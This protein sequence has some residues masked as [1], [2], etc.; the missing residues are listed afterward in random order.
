MVF[1]KQNTKT[2]FNYKVEAHTARL[3]REHSRK[4]KTNKKLRAT[5]I[6]H[7]LNWAVVMPMFLGEVRVGAEKTILDV[8][9][10][11]GSDWLVV[12]DSEC[13]NCDGNRIDNSEAERTSEE[14]TERLYGSAAL[15][16]STWRDIVCLTSSS[17]SCVNEF[18]YFSFITQ[19]GINDP[20]EGIL[21]MCQNKQMILSQDELVIGPLFAEQL[22]I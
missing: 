13:S 17:Y 18:E 21:G 14:V 20:I 4:I 15:T 5:T 6:D 9:Y 7:D 11:T 10:D 1:G 8:V 16:G 3:S 12:P 22:F 19:T 2:E